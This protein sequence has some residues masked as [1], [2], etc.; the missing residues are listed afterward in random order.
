MDTGSTFSAITGAPC[1]LYL[2]SGR[3]HGSLHADFVAS[4]ALK[5]TDVGARG[6]TQSCRS[7][8]IQLD[9]SERWLPPSGARTLGRHRSAQD[10]AQARLPRGF[11]VRIEVSV[12][13]LHQRFGQLST[14]LFRER[15]GCLGDSG[16]DLCIVTHGGTS[17][18]Q[19]IAAHQSSIGSSERMMLGKSI[20]N[21]QSCG[22]AGRCEAT[23]REDGRSSG[24]RRSGLAFVSR[25]A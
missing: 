11:C 1:G 10:A 18:V 7:L 24:R 19:A 14:F 3:A 9:A 5:Q 25:R 21:F 13:A 23:D 12:E 15:Q 4:P 6:N 22:T 2:L 20:K 17:L 8:C 16:A